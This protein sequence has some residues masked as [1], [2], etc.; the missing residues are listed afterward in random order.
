MP[1]RSARRASVAVGT[2]VGVGGGGGHAVTNRD[3]DVSFKAREVV[4]AYAGHTAPA[5]PGSARQSYL[6]VSEP[7][8][9]TSN[10]KGK[11]S[12][13][14]RLYE[15]RYG[16]AVGA[17]GH[18][19]RHTVARSMSTKD[20]AAV[21]SHLQSAAAKPAVRGLAP[22][23]SEDP[24]APDRSPSKR[25]VLQRLRTSSIGLLTCALQSCLGWE[26]E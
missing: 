26:T 10:P 22:L 24:L 2:G 3:A 21:Q 12:F 8:T 4:D 13:D 6:Q 20:R 14:P 25:T 1:K 7:T 23:L 18:T 11:Q 15:N 19:R 5:A 16:D 17:A 9:R